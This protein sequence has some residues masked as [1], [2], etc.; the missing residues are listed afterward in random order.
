MFLEEDVHM[1][2][3]FL[4]S[5]SFKHRLNTEK[6][7]FPLRFNEHNDFRTV[8]FVLLQLFRTKNEHLSL[9]F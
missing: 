1:Y 2:F 8:V 5:V 3:C 4:P 7:V 6:K 9:K